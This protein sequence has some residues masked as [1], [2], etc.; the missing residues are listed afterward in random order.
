MS[1]LSYLRGFVPWFVFGG[2]SSV[3]WQWGALAA[4]AI[5]LVLLVRQRRSGVP[6]DAL[7]LE[8]TTVV[9]FVLLTALAFAAPHSP[10]QPYAGV[11]S[12]SWLALTAWGT[13]AVRRPF[14][15]GIAK[16]STPREYW[17]TPQFVSIATVIAT[18]WAVCFTLTAAVTAVL[19]VN[20][21]GTL[22]TTLCQVVGF[23][24]PAVFTSRYPKIMQARYAA[25]AAG[26]GI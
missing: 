7:V 5:G 14:T 9:Y 4:L 10:L 18:V 24:L 21:A 11:L 23:V 25:A 20:N 19:D 12:F 8:T 13:L 22:A 2:L 17:D 26:S 1:M 16:R 6:A 15:L 3:G